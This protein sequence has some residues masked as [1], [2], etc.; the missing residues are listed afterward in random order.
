M[1]FELT[2]RWLSEIAGWQVAKPA[3][4]LLSGGAVLKAEFDGRVLRGLVLDGR[5]RLACGLKI[6][7]KSDVTNLCSCRDA[8]STG[9]ICAH[10]TAVGLEFIKQGVAR[11][12]ELPSGEQRSPQPAENQQDGE[13]EQLAPVLDEDWVERVKS[14]RFSLKL[15]GNLVRRP[16]AEASGR[17]DIQI[18]IALKEAGESRFPEHVSVKTSEAGSLFAAVVSHPGLRIG[19]Q[20]VRVAVEPGRDYQPH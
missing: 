11:K 1:A 19:D 13:V 20:G 14:G 4:A 12:K 15:T 7:G 9:A 16:R 5:K 10:S 2:E 8:R 18:G 17:A 6:D 3:K